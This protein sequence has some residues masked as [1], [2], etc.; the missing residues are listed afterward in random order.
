MSS[1]FLQHAQ[2][3][4]RTVTTIRFSANSLSHYM[5]C[6]RFWYNYKVLG[7]RLVRS[8]VGR[9]AGTA[10]HGGIAVLNKGGAVA[11]Q[12]AA[13]DATL[14]AET[15]I[16]ADDY[17][18]AA[19][20]KDALAAFRAEYQPAL[21]NWTIEEV[22]AHGEVELGQVRYHIPVWREERIAHVIYEFRRDM[23]AVSP[24]GLRFLW[25]FKTA[26]RDEQAEVAASQVSNA[27]KGYCRTYEMQ[28][29]DRPVH[30]VL[31]RRLI[32]RKPTKTG[33]AFTF[34]ED[35]PIYY[36]KEILDEWQRQTLRT[37][38]EIL[39]RDPADA[40]AWPLSG[41]VSGACR[42]QWGCCDYVGVCALPP[43]QRAL[44]LSTDEFESS[45]HRKH[46]NHTTD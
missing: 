41:T 10:E 33:V 36:A 24:D 43:D 34:P 21:K 16:P 31:Q 4:G 23:V 17:R 37:A 20:L 2:Q 46:E 18:T 40:D 42:S 26:S 28:Y 9:I 44:K 32:M 25:D 38:V 11:A 3:D 35:G 27:Y 29:P 22:E 5:V 39:E 14:A 15:P 6:R 45:N 7:R 12:E 30:G 1:P 13:I 8:S 19:Y